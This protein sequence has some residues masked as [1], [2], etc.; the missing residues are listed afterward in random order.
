MF[1]PLQDSDFLS[2]QNTF[3]LFSH[4]LS[5]FFHIGPIVPK[6]GR[7]LWKPFTK[8][9]LVMQDFGKLS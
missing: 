1:Y 9:K 2:F 8:I 4:T 6:Y 3:D 7:F 5:T